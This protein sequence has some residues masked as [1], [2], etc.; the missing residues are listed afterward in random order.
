TKVD[1]ADFNLSN[2]EKK[3]ALE[4]LQSTHSFPLIDYFRN[5]R[6]FN[7]A[8]HIKST[9]YGMGKSDFPLIKNHAPKTIEDMKEF[10]HGVSKEAKKMPSYSEIVNDYLKRNLQVEGVGKGRHYFEI[11]HLES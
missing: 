9:V 3:Q 5:E 8:L 10:I 4:V 7:K 1:L 6:K 2:S 11:F